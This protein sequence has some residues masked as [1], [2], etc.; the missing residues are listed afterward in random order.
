MN[1]K[2]LGYYFANILQLRYSFAYIEWF[3]KY[4]R[5]LRKFKNLHHGKD[6][7]I[8]GNG[9]SL[10]KIDLDQLSE[11][12][13]FG[14]N[15]IFLLFDKVNYRPTYHVAVNRLVIEQS[16]KEFEALPCTSFLSFFP[17]RNKFKNLEHINFILTGGPSVFRKNLVGLVDEGWTVTYVAMQIAYYMGF[18]NVFLVGVDHNFIVSGAPNEPQLFKGDDVN[19]FDSN[20][21][22][23]MEWQ[24]PDLRGSESSYH[25]AKLCY[26]KSGR[27]IFDATVDGK[28]QVFPKLSF[29]KALV[30]C[31]KRNG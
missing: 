2:Y 21:F 11:Y 1:S 23:N 20:Y 27:N 5:T 8:L 7:F 17:S 25:L 29:E 19:H 30:T 3:L 22:S 10:N 9:P 18:K 6:C 4:A 13:T 24:P 28:L 16:I 14:L 12:Y 31:K 15:K 26:E